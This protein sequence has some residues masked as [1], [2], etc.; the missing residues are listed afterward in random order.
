MRDAFAPLFSFPVDFPPP[1][2]N[3]QELVQSDGYSVE[4][5]KSAVKSAHASVRNYIL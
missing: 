5:K 3:D 4:V 2:P 1:L